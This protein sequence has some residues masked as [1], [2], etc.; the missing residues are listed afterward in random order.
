[1]R[2][3]GG[4]ERGHASSEQQ[5][6]GRS[7]SRKG[8]KRRGFGVMFN[9]TCHG[10]ECRDEEAVWLKPSVSSSSESAA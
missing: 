7:W 2:V 4:T 3:W 8:L 1:M 5:S 9:F 6:W 10:D